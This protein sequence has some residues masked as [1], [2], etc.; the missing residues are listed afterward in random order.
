MTDFF[1]TAMVQCS[2]DITS[3]IFDIVREHFL[4]RK[5]SGEKYPRLDLNSMK[6]MNKY[7]LS[8]KCKGVRIEDGDIRN[9]I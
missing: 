3:A 1:I 2:H 5:E 8:S 7:G 4:K 9:V 6:H